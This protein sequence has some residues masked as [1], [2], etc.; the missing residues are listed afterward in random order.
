M[1]LLCS[2]DGFGGA[3]LRRLR[4]LA[5]FSVGYSCQ[6]THIVYYA[7]FLVYGPAYWTQRRQC[8]LALC[9][10]YQMVFIRRR[11]LLGNENGR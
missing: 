4:R 3:A 9:L 8:C 5:A 11:Q 10:R 7:L 2:G 1:L 6:R